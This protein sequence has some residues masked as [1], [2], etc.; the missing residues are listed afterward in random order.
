MVTYIFKPLRSQSNNKHIWT[1]F[2]MPISKYLIVNA[3]DYGYSSERDDGIL[4]CYLDNSITCVS[5]M[6]NGFSA[7]EGVRKAQAA[8]LPMGNLHLYFY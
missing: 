2:S 7:E 3:D 4:A 6:V 5:L 1:D 8:G